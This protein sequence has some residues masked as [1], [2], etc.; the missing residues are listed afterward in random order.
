MREN[1][2]GSFHLMYAIAIIG[3]LLEH[4][5]PL[6]LQDIFST[7][8]E[9]RGSFP[10]VPRPSPTIKGAMSDEQ[11]SQL[12]CGELGWASMFDALQKAGKQRVQTKRG[13]TLLSRTQGPLAETT[14]QP[15][16]TS[17][18]STPL[19]QA[20]AQR[21][22]RFSTHKRPLYTQL[23]PAA[24]GQPPDSELSLLLRCR[25][26]QEKAGPNNGTQ[27]STQRRLWRQ[28]VTYDRRRARSQQPAAD[29]RGVCAVRHDASSF[30]NTRRDRLDPVGTLVGAERTLQELCRDRKYCG[31][32]AQGRAFQHSK[33]VER[34]P[35]SLGVL[36][37][38]PR[39]SR[40]ACY[41]TSSNLGNTSRKPT[42]FQP[43]NSDSA[44]PSS[45]P[46]LASNVSTSISSASTSRWRSSTRSHRSTSWAPAT[47][48][49]SSATKPATEQRYSAVAV[50]SSHKLAPGWCSDWQFEIHARDPCANVKSKNWSG[51]PEE[52]FKNRS[53]QTLKPRMST[54]HAMSTAGDVIKLTVGSLTAVERDSSL[55]PRLK[56]AL[57]ALRQSETATSTADTVRVL[58]EPTA[59]MAEPGIKLAIGALTAVARE[60]GFDPRLNLVLT[61]LRSW[62]LLKW[63]WGAEGD[64]AEP[65]DLFTSEWGT[66]RPKN[67]LFAALDELEAELDEMDVD[68][69]GRAPDSQVAATERAFGPTLPTSVLNVLLPFVRCR[70]MLVG[71]SVVC[72]RWSEPAHAALLEI[73]QLVHYERTGSFALAASMRKHPLGDKYADNPAIRNLVRVA[74]PQHPGARLPASMKTGKI[75]RLDMTDLGSLLIACLRLAIFE[76]DYVILEDKKPLSK[77]TWAAVNQVIG[78]LEEVS[79]IPLVEDEIGFMAVFRMRAAMRAP[80]RKWT[81]WG[82]EFLT[83]LR[84]AAYPKLELLTLG[85]RLTRSPGPLDMSETKF[86]E[87]IGRVTPNVKEFNL[88]DVCTHLHIPLLLRALPQVEKLRIGNHQLDKTTLRVLHNHRPLLIFLLDSSACSEQDFFA[89]LEHRG[90][91]L[92]SITVTGRLWRADPLSKSS[93]AFRRTFTIQLKGSVD[94]A[95][96]ADQPGTAAGG[97]L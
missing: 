25:T 22:H 75:G 51:A 97:H 9:G 31:E 24:A 79:I 67:P 71:A 37:Y 94:R 27:V 23:C 47:I 40:P 91:R 63:E 34:V 17:F 72:R 13:T 85:S 7:G 21:K 36:F 64:F 28:R 3:L 66:M 8:L 2:L 14:S 55:D 32:V 20:R 45:I 49:S 95:S 48:A 57:E 30:R 29:D 1:Q 93:P 39:T 74:D 54:A 53:L 58:D 83:S 80:P 52:G 50:S 26:G 77:E 88:V 69:S 87:D 81:A 35:A 6:C 43:P 11:V 89:L 70:K 56:R 61:T 44:S 73:V 19:P 12:G 10:T 38:P 65:L 92:V 46:P 76:I 62:L 90:S 60:T 68:E 33:S 5:R 18:A 78:G 82:L 15:N 59:A 84:T 42:T 86:C 4:H 41:Q 16:P 96:V